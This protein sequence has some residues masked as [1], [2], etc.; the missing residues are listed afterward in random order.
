[1]RKKGAFTIGQDE[2]SCVVYGMPMVAYNIGAVVK[3]A[4][5]ANIAYILK[6]HL[7]QL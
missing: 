5:L 2:A 1:M 7:N 6:G 3:Q 4:P